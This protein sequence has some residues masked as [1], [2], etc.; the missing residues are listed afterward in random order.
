[1]NNTDIVPAHEQVTALL[2]R[3]SAVLYSQAMD[4]KEEP[5]PDDDVFDHWYN[6]RHVVAVMGINR[7]T[8][9]EARLAE[10]IT[11]ALIAAHK[12]SHPPASRTCLPCV[13]E[14]NCSMSSVISQVRL[15]MAQEA[16]DAA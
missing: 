2:L 8:L 11:A 6:V 15:L 16:T 13:G 4:G 14:C 12:I 1:M 5:D 3:V 10:Q 9:L 7:T